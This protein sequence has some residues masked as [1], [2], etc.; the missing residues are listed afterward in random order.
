MTNREQLI[1]EIEQAP[2]ALVEEILDFCLFVKQRQQAK[3]TAS[4][5]S[6]QPQTSGILDLLERVKEI[7]AQVPAEEWDKL[8]HDGSINH[9]HYLYGASK[10]EE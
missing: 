1:K 8:P 3:A 5:A 9:D 4:A 10:I 6:S 7:Q 2:D